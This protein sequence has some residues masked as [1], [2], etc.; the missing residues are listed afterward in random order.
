MVNTIDSLIEEIAPQI[1]YE[2]I[3]FPDLLDKAI[4]TG[5]TDELK[6]EIYNIIS[7][8]PK[9]PQTLI[10]CSC[11]TY[12]KCFEK[13][14]SELGRSAIR[15]DRPMAEQ[16]IKAGRNLGVAVALHSTIE[17]TKKLLEEIA[18]YQKVNI[19]I[20]EIICD[21]AWEYK[22]KGDDRVYFIEISK[23]VENS[24][25][26]L[27]AIILAQ[28]SMAP[29]SKILESKLSIPIFTSPEIAIKNIASNFIV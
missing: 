2:N 5:I 14:S 20:R 9:D 4:E 24:A 15:I 19:S 26:G 23:A 10:L 8:I 11:S 3:I 12:G 1:K 28:G 18:K 25:E 17:P 22:L 29:A 27:D 16:A 6:Q 21:K 13:I 7:A